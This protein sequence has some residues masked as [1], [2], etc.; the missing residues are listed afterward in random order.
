MLSQFDRLIDDL[1]A[2]N[3]HG[4]KFERWEI[5]VLL[6]IADS[7]F[8]KPPAVLNRYR[9]AV[10]RQLA[11]GATVPMRLSEFLALKAA[12]SKPEAS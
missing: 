8:N 4:S 12:K 9:K 11:K 6:D 1:I 3:I 5:D 10:H 7:G 2:G